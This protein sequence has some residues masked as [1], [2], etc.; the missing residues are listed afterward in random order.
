MLRTTFLTAAIT[1]ALA[2]VAMAVPTSTPLALPY[3]NGPVWSMLVDG[4][5]AYVG[6]TFTAAGGTATGPLALVRSSDGSLV[7]AFR[8]IT[9]NSTPANVSDSVLNVAA[10]VSDGAGGWYAGGGFNQVDG[11]FRQALV[12]LRPDGSPDPAFRADVVGQVDALALR[13]DTLFVAGSLFAAGGEASG[14]LVAIDARTGARLDWEPDVSLNEIDDLELDGDRLYAGGGSLVALDVATGKRVRWV[15]R[16][17]GHVYDL[18]VRNGVVYIAGSYHRYEGTREVYGAAA[19]RTSDGGPVTMATDVPSPRSVVATEQAVVWGISESGRTLLATDPATGADLGWFASVNGSGYGRIATDGQRLFASNLTGPANGLGAFDVRDGS[20]VAWNPGFAGTVVVSMLAAADGQVAVGG[21]LGSIGAVARKNLA[22]FDLRTGAVLPFDPGLDV[23]YKFPGPQDTVR[24]LALTK[25]GGTLYVGGRFDTVG[26]AGHKNLAALDPVR[27]ALLPFP[28][29]DVEVHDLAAGGGSLF[30]GKALYGAV[31]GVVIEGGLTAIDLA[32]ATTR[33]WAPDT[34]CSV[35]A[36]TVSGPTLHAGG[37]FRQVGGAGRVGLASFRIADLAP[38]EGGVVNGSVSGLA[39]DGSGGV[40]VGGAFTGN[41]RHFGPG[42]AVLADAPAVDGPVNAFSLDG[43]VLTLGGAFTHLA[44]VPRR[45]LGQVRLADGAVTSFDPEPGGF[46][47]GVAGLADGGALAAGG[48]GWTALSVTAGLARF[49]SS[50]AVPVPAVRAAPT[51]RGD[52]YVDGAQRTDGGEFDPALRRE[53]HWLRCDANGDA[54][55]DTGVQDTTSYKLRAADVGHR[56]RVEARAFGDAGGSA[57][58]RSAP[59]P[60]VAGERP[61]Y[62]DNGAPTLWGIPRAGQTVSA[63][64]GFLEPAATSYKYLWLRCDD[65]FCE[66]IE[67]DAPTY[68]LT[69]ADVGKQIVVDVTASNAAGSA[70]QT[71]QNQEFVVLAGAA[72]GV[73]PTGVK[74]LAPYPSTAGSTAFASTEQDLDADVHTYRYTWLRCAD[75]TG[76]TCVRLPGHAY[77]R[78]YGAADVGSRMRV[79]VV[80]YDH[81]GESYERISDPGPVIGPD[82]NPTPTPTPFPT[83]TPTASPTATASPTPTADP[84]ATP[85][86]TASPTATATATPT[87]NPTA[88]A[89]PN[90]TPAATAGPSPTPAADPG[91]TPIAPALPKRRIS[92]PSPLPTTHVVATHDR[93]KVRVRSTV[94]T[95]VT[96]RVKRGGATLGRATAT[97]KAGVTRTLT[98]KVRRRGAVTVEVVTR[99]GTVRHRARVG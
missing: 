56:L 47:T 24:P 77:I 14:N 30:V 13:G 1:L 75:A 85:T 38:V 78:R 45:N 27:G 99:A 88:T 48:F 46:V 5:T 34:D 93:V 60:F 17:N 90:A 74:P 21:A 89:E 91:P 6:G 25:V 96:V 70:H 39:P 43:G 97:L 33:A 36:L 26:G 64:P 12:H 86:A 32:S 23:T 57:V 84:T 68:V 22:A 63:D 94:A 2:P 41:L 19:V 59:G 71:S 92:A 79:A 49:G 10:A 62:H 11:L 67:H 16:W 82:P 29:S 3:V 87:A 8:G 58:S 55:V 51:V 81:D 69:A 50:G 18:A 52:A 53:V 7:R 76:D 66:R 80:T 95:P 83:P 73:A 31:G 98:V 28:A 9:A 54:C 61:T 4:D 20:P 37:C 65:V 72:S 15:P 44:G 40:W 35:D 42:G